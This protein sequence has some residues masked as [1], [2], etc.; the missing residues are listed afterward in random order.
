[1]VIKTCS[2]RRSYFR[3]CILSVL[4]SVAGVCMFVSVTGVISA[5]PVSQF[6]LCH[7]EF[8][9]FMWNA[10]ATVT[11]TL[12]INKVIYLK[13]HL[14]NFD[15]LKFKLVILSLIFFFS[16][17]LCAA[18]VSFPEWLFWQIYTLVF[19]MFW[20]SGWWWWWC[21]PGPQNLRTSSLL[22]AALLA[23]QTCWSKHEA[24]HL[25]WRSFVAHAL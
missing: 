8:Y 9:D 16:L 2:C 14:N 24:R 5:V 3:K 7:C 6:V 15:Q 21:G 12:W 17:R 4:V 13:N 20:M 25:I 18:L 11:F 23:G 10:T 1:M 19:K 22:A